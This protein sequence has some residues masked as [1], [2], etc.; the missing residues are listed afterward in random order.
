[1]W[2]VFTIGMSVKF[3]RRL[4]NTALL[5]TPSAI[6]GYPG[7]TS[8]DDTFSSERATFFARKF[9]LR[10]EESLGTFSYQTSSRS[11]RNPTR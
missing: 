3:G 11:G 6:F 2:E 4:V 9:T 1:M 10:A 5:C 8:R 7:A